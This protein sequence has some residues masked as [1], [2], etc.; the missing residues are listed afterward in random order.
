M[1]KPYAGGCAC[2]AVR[3]EIG[4]EPMMQIQCQCRDCQRASGGGHAN[5]LAVPRESLKVTGEV[6]YFAVRGDSGQ[7][8]RRGFCPTCGTPLFGMPD[9][10]PHIVGVLAG[11]LDEPGRFAPQMVMYTSSA[12][13]WD[14]VDP[15]LPS[16]PKLMPMG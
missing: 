6:R 3:Y 8:V 1:S 14:R 7:P 12:Q 4:A 15:A 9:V 11:S 2:G 10:A 13:P 5:A 16:Y